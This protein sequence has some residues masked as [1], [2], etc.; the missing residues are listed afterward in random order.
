M[1]PPPAECH[2]MGGSRSKSDHSAS[3][4]D[5]SPQPGPSGLG[6]GL[7]SA[8]GADR[9]RSEYGGW[10]SPSPSGAADDDCSSTFN[11]VNLDKNDSFRSVLRLIR[12]FHSLEEPASV[13]PNRRKTSLAPVYG[14]QSESSTAL[15]LPLSPLIQSLL[16][17]TNLA[18]SKYVEEQTLHGFLLVPGR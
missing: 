9:S 11:S 8:T 12:D 2:G 1:P 4:H 3:H 15:H 17:D 16:E 13:A 7:R 18:L 6:L 14:L 10:S 5:R